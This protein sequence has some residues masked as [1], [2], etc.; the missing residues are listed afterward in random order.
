MLNMSPWYA[1]AA[2]T[3]HVPGCVRWNLATT[4]ISLSRLCLHIRFWSLSLGKAVQHW[5]KCSGTPQRQPGAGTHGIQ[6]LHL[7]EFKVKEISYCCLEILNGIVQRRWNQTWRF[8]I[9]STNI[10]TVLDN[11]FLNFMKYNWEQNLL[12]QII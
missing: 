4:M 5:S 1:L 11:T 6:E 7:L 10:M 12:T 8:T 2:K 3:D 9:L